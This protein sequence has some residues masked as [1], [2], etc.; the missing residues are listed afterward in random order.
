MLLYDLI[1]VY[2]LLTT[3]IYGLSVILWVLHAIIAPSFFKQPTEL[4]WNSNNIQVRI[5]TV[6][7]HSLCKTTAE[8]AS[9]YFDDIHIISETT[10][11]NI[12]GAT[13]HTVPSS[14]KCDATRKGR[15]LEWARQNITCEKEYVLYL[16]EDTLITDFQGLPDV[17]ICQ[18][19][20]TPM[21]SNSLLTFYTEIYRSGYQTEQRSFNLLKYPLYVWGG[22]VAVRTTLEDTVTWDYNTITE[23]TNFAWRS[24]KKQ[25]ISFATV[26]QEFRNQSPVRIKDL[27]TQ[28]RRWISGTLNDL[29]IL[30]LK[31]RIYSVSR[32]VNW[33]LSPLVML[34][35]II[36][37][38]LSNPIL[39]STV[40]ISVVIAELLALMLTTTIG[41]YKYNKIEPLSKII[42]SIPL[43]PV[44][45]LINGI[46]AIYGLLKPAQ[47]FKVTP[48]KDVQ[49]VIKENTIEEKE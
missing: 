1:V 14:F 6:D 15:A 7:N 27:I 8:Y 39:N 40:F 11:K 20:E 33:A 35:T 18:F 2:I 38:I 42:L 21:Q 12:S 3:S 25:P 13:I 32:I 31:Y 34:N 24:A 43:T 26:L 28:R 45:A 46:G 9:E 36:I 48:K 5:L 30:P 49:K 10:I 47:D 19:T 4:T 44:L 29:H 41:V 17:D 37:Y 22:G 16:D 23:D